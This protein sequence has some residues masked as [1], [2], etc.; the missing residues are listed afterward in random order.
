MSAARTLRHGVD[1]SQTVAVALKTLVDELI[2]VE[3]LHHCVVAGRTSSAVVVL[4]K[5]CVGRT[6]C[7]AVGVC[8]CA[9]LAGCM[10][11]KTVIT[12]FEKP[13]CVAK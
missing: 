8:C 12:T 4:I 3:D 2:A 11:G 7:A 9:S 10:A 1:A 5:I 6:I 13:I